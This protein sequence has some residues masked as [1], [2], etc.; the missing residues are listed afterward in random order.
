V[1]NQKL[2][3]TA[4]TERVRAEALSMRSGDDMVKVVAALWQ[5]M[6]NLGIE[7]PGANITFIDEEQDLGAGTTTWL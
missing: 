3:R 4:A 2:T 5:E 1:N 6:R 7:T